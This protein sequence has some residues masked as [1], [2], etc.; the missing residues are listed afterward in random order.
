QGRRQPSRPPRPQACRKRTYRHS[1][2]S[3]PP[4]RGERGDLIHQTRS[5]R[6]RTMNTDIIAEC[7]N[8][9][10]ADTPFPQVVKNLVGA[11][12]R[13]YNADLT[14]LR[15]TYYGADGGS[16]DE[17]LPLSAAP[18]IAGAFD[19]DRVA[20]TVRAIQQGQIGYAE[21]LRNIMSAGCASYAVFIQGR[22]V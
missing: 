4:A 8:L 21:F 2:R 10:F 3:A 13:A 20:A 16:Y 17:T 22:K 14:K 19:K 1:P 15:S 7:M 18:P 9:S 12:V 6:S 11:G 5:V